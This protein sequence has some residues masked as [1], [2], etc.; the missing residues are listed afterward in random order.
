MRVAS[1]DHRENEVTRKGFELTVTVRPRP[2]LITLSMG[3]YEGIV[4]GDVARTSKSEGAMHSMLR[5]F[6]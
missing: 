2:T 4:D 6:R 3:T 5:T 1:L